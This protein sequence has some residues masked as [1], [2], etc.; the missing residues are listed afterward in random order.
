MLRCLR[1][2]KFEAAWKLIVGAAGWCWRQT[3]VPSP[4][5]QPLLLAV[6]SCCPHN[7]TSRCADGTECIS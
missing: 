2:G 4:C 1:A 5:H 3:A 7:S 6:S